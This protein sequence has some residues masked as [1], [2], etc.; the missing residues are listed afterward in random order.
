MKADLKASASVFPPQA[1]K[2][3]AGEFKGLLGDLLLIDAAAFIGSNKKATEEDWESLTLLF[4]QIL[5]LDPFFKQAYYLVQS[6][7]TW[8]AKRHGDANELLAISR[9]SRTWDWLPGFF[10]GF[11]HFYFLNDN[12]SASRHLMDASRVPSAPL[13]LAT[14]AARLAQK[15]GE[16]ITAIVFLEA[17]L[18]KIDDEEQRKV[19]EARIEALK[20]ILVLDKAIKSYKER[21]GT[22]PEKLDD[23]IN[24]GVIASLPKN[25][26][27]RPY[28]LKGEKVQF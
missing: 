21:F 9:D 23:L 2:I 6:S 4:K 14:L 12:E 1:L 25:P 5:A 8:D 28:T 13:G 16:T 18:D 26:Y 11:N 17:M 20:G 7:L 3:M 24:R 22:T 27:E 10:L 19:I 15:A